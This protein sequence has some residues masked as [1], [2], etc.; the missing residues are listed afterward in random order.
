MDRKRWNSPFGSEM[1]R[2]EKI[3]IYLF[4][5]FFPVDL[6]R[7]ANGSIAEREIRE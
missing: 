3:V 5:Q 1:V 7:F 4:G 6:H 2:T